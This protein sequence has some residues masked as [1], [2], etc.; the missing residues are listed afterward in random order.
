[1]IA[2]ISINQEI[3]TAAVLN[4]EFQRARDRFPHTD[5]SKYKCKK[6][7]GEEYRINEF[8]IDW[9][10]RSIKCMPLIYH[11]RLFRLKQAIQRFWN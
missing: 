4:M 9:F 3:N 8:A 7:F 6:Y 11:L 5:G 1:M 10:P 2:L